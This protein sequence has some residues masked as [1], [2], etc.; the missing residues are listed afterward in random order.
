MLVVFRGR[1]MCVCWRGIFCS[2]FGPEESKISSGEGRLYNQEVCNLYHSCNTITVTK[3]SSKKWALYAPR[4]RDEKFFRKPWVTLSGYQLRMEIVNF[5][6]DVIIYDW[7]QQFYTGI[8]WLK[9][10]SCFW[11]SKWHVPSVL[12]CNALSTPRYEAPN[13]VPSWYTR[14][15]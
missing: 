13:T 9:T 2:T 4:R 10:F 8:E 6:Q 14:R 7:K 5:Y 12:P 11:H 1:R 15:D 3:Q